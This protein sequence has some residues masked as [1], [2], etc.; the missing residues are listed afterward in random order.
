M[1]LIT[2]PIT[3][4]WDKGN[5]GKNLKAHDVSDAEAEEVFFDK[6]KR[7]L[8]DQLHSNTEKRNIAI[9]M[10]K[11]GRILFTVFTI[12]KNCIRIISSRPLNR[13]ERNLYK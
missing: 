2:E 8:N 13:K 1:V 5:S 3:F 6:N 12:R 11:A 7:V 4:Q 10:T 9:G